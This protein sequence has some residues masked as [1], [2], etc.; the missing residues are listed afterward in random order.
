[1]E[2][3]GIFSRAP[4][5][6]S[7]IPR[8]ALPAASSFLLLLFFSGGLQPGP[9][10]AAPDAPPRTRY[11]QDLGNGIVLDRRKERSW[12][13]CGY[14][15][16]PRRGMCRGRP[17]RLSWRAAV[18]YCRSLKLGGK[19]WRLPSIGELEEISEPGPERPRIN[20]E[21]FPGIKP[22]E[23][24]S[25]NLLHGSRGVSIYVFSYLRGYKFGVT[26]G[27]FFTRCTAPP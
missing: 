5:G 7:P 14:G 25:S 8:F 16:K 24:W 12:Q 19:K 3:E 4:G 23:Y 10:N 11:L 9:V 26:G 27:K 2:R 13:K 18:R 1:M 15:Q 17:L 6:K 20:L 21:A 22:F